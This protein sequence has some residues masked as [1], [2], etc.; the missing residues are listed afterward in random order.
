MQGNNALRSPDNHY[1]AISGQLLLVG[2]EP[3]GD[4][5]RFKADNI[6]DF[7]SVYRS[8]KLN[9]SKDESVQLRLDG[10]DAPEIHYA[11]HMQPRGEIA[12]NVMLGDV[13][14]F[15]DLQFNKLRVIA[16][17]PPMMEATILTHM[18]D[19][20][21][22]PVSYLLTDNN[23]R[24]FSNGEIV[25][26][27]KGLLDRTANIQLLKRGEAYPLLYTSTPTANRKY[28]REL[29][30]KTRDDRAGVWI[31]DKTASFELYDYRSVEP[32]NGRPNSSKNIS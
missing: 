26:V 6:E 23:A 29:A 24:E 27:N 2:Y 10:I 14:G 28:I 16:S 22:R 17:T 25:E 9:P 11:S 21:G 32:P 18:F 8:Y 3:D 7:E 31:D 30:R 1:K 15:S 13:L 5:L 20:H 4:S 12:R 19:P